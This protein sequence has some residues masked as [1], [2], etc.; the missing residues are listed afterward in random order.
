M[1]NRVDKENPL[2]VELF[3]QTVQEIWNK[4]SHEELESLIS[5]MPQRIQKCE[6]REEHTIK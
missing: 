2:R 6:D 1:K 3:K 4:V 5:S